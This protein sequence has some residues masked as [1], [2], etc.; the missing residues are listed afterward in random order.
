MGPKGLNETV[1]NK[2]AATLRDGRGI[3]GGSGADKGCLTVP[4]QIVRSCYLQLM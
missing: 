1:L 2:E 3:A 4:N